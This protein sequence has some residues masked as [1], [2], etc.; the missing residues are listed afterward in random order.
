M[1]EELKKIQV[2]M[3]N[4]SQKYGVGIKVD[5]IKSINIETK[6]EG[7]IYDPKVIKEGD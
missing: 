6:E 1:E 5:T 4:F 2:M 3:N 7:Y